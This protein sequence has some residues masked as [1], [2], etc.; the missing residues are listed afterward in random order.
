MHCA[1]WLAERVAPKWVHRAGL[2]VLNIMVHYILHAPDF[3]NVITS[4]LS[5]LLTR[6]NNRIV[7]SAARCMQFDDASSAVVI[8]EHGQ[9]WDSK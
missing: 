7:P 6:E 8:K 4:P 2:D 1:I 3:Q 9:I 5:W